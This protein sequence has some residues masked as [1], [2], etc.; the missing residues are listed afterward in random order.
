MEHDTDK[1]KKEQKFLIEEVFHVTYDSTCTGLSPARQLRL[2]CVPIYI[3]TY[4]RGV[5]PGP[6]S[7]MIY[8]SHARLD[9]MK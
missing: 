8:T 3:C 7:E 9:S 6:F 1:R 2:I 4:R 5:F